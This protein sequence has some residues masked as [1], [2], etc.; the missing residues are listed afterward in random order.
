MRKLTN[1]ETNALL[2]MEWTAGDLETASIEDE[3]HLLKCAIFEPGAAR[4]ISVDT[5]SQAAFQAQFHWIVYQAIVEQVK[6]T[7]FKLVMPFPLRKVVEPQCAGFQ[8][9]EGTNFNAEWEALTF[10]ADPSVA[11]VSVYLSRIKKRLQRRLHRLRMSGLRDRLVECDNDTI[12]SDSVATQMINVLEQNRGAFDFSAY[13]VSWEEQEEI[14]KKFGVEDMETVLTGFGEWDRMI[15]PAIGQLGALVG[16][17]H[18]ISGSTGQGK[19][20]MGVTLMRNFVSNGT[21]TAYLNFELTKLELIARSACAFTGQ[22][23]YGMRN[24]NVDAPQEVREREWRRIW[25]DWSRQFRGYDESNQMV[26]I[27]KPTRNWGEIK[28]LLAELSAVGIK[29]VIIDTINR[30]ADRDK[31][32]QRHAEMRDICRD[33]DQIAPDLNIA[34]FLMAQENREKRLRTNKR[35]VIWDI[36][37]SGEL[38]N[39]S[40]SVTQ[41]YRSDIYE[42]TS[43]IECVVSKSRG[44]GTEGVDSF[45]IAWQPGSGTYIQME[46][47]AIE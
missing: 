32:D 8:W 11:G 46:R 27:N 19:S 39:V 2:E 1:E 23:A 41:I 45:P 12:V 38:G 9:P 42:G 20:T 36:A 26:L 17:A 7:D 15:A 4:K 6:E 34:L 30:I 24:F 18:T 37:E 21:P 28:D 14:A 33:L 29:A 22:N 3:W 13:K 16:A 47:S 31:Q 35:P 44:T 40:N 5:L 25:D 43:Y 10:V